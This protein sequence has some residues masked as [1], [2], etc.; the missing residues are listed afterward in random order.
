[1]AQSEIDRLMERSV[2][3]NKQ[4]LQR[5]AA[6]K[7]RKKRRSEA[8]SPQE[9]LNLNWKYIYTSLKTI[10][11][12]L[13]AIDMQTEPTPKT[14][15]SRIQAEL[16]VIMAKLQEKN[17]TRLGNQNIRSEIGHVVN[18]LA[19]TQ[20]A[21]T[22][23]VIAPA[24]VSRLLSDMSAKLTNLLDE[25]AVR[26]DHEKL[27]VAQF[28]YDQKH[29]K[30]EEARKK[31]LI[32]VSTMTPEKRK[33]ASLK[34]AMNFVKDTSDEHIKQLEFEANTAEE[35]ELL[36]PFEVREGQ[37]LNK[38]FKQFLKDEAAM[39]AAIKRSGVSKS[40]DLE[41]VILRGP[42]TV[43]TSPQ[44]KETHLAAAKVS[45]QLVRFPGVRYGG[46]PEPWRGKPEFIPHMF[47]L[48]DQVLVAIRTM[49]KAGPAVK[50][51]PTRKN[52]PVL[53]APKSLK[54]GPNLELI[55]QDVADII[56]TR[57]GRV[58]I[59]VLKAADSKV[60]SIVNKK[61][62]GF[63][64]VWLLPNSVYQKIGPFSLDEVGLP[65]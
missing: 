39:K 62:P 58:Y 33:T 7:E 30:L 10:A 32:A 49:G 5:M 40:D 23:K 1:M 38:M 56:Q 24:K 36:H 59:D 21:L 48:L 65:F 16:L 11:Y 22:E 41:F 31:A 54:E 43:R 47:V 26:V 45:Y 61:F 52:L 13:S 55:R 46:N 20:Y 53:K 51:K 29:A 18:A 19:G 2:K 60:L 12:N 3:R 17:I 50:K 14:K 28:E 64:F 35:P 42:V 34:E 4:A 27:Q 25:L 8:S 37:D 63:R 15:F 9:V 57:T 6:N 44:L